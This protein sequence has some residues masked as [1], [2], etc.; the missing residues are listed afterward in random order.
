MTLM[1]RRQLIASALVVATAALGGWSC[2]SKSDTGPSASNGGK[3]MTVGFS[4]IGAE[5][6][7]R[8]ANTDNIKGEAEKRGIDLRFSDAQQKQDNQIK[9][10][11]NFIAQG[12][13]VIAFAPVVN[14]GWE[15]VLKEAK[16]AG[17]PVV[18]SDRR[19]QTDDPTLVRTFVGTDAY[20]EG[21]AA[22]EEMVKITD[23]KAT[24]VELEGTPGSDPAILRKKG[25]HEVID[26]HPDMKIIKEQTGNFNRADGRTVMEA[27]LNSTEGN[28][29]TALFAHNDDMAL[30][31]IQAIEAAGKKPGVDIKIVSIDAVKGAFEAIEAGKMNATVEC[32]PL[33]GKPLFDVITKIKNGEEVPAEVISQPVVFDKSNAAAELPKRVY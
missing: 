27:F 25:F 1:N 3:Q 28:Q 20:K 13:D 26:K 33:L 11:Q 17:I 15:P 5:S 18:L 31:A 16:K 7:W 22:G 14:T 9:A 8:T 19:I 12:V 4:Q 32:S 30:G 2:D 21:V 6:A 24:I 10:I 29:I 23:G